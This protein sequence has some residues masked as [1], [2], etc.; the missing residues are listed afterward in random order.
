MPC[1]RRGLTYDEVVKAACCGR[2]SEQ[3]QA[4]THPFGGCPGPR[5]ERKGGYSVRSRHSYAGR[6]H[7]RCQT[8]ADGGGNRKAHTQG[9]AHARHIKPADA[10]GVKQT[11]STDQRQHHAPLFG[12]RAQK[13]RRTLPEILECD[14]RL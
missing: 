10:G 6:E 1:R 7:G 12:D 9:L 5:K 14:K 8:P 11:V 2:N 3:P 4:K 13:S